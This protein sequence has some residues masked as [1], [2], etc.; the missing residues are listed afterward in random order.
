[1]RK[2]YQTVLSYS[3]HEA[4]ICIIIND[5]PSKEIIKTL[6]FPKEGRELEHVRVRRKDVACEYK[7]HQCNSSCQNHETLKAAHC[8]SAFIC[9]NTFLLAP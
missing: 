9:R 6:A 3:D 4:I 1:M 5:L 2:Y 8:T 7:V